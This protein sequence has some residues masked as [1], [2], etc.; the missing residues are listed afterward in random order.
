LIQPSQSTV[1]LE[2]LT[3][4]DVCKI[5]D[6]PSARLNGLRWLRSRARQDERR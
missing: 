5:A 4:H 6:A 1:R 3:V 2:I